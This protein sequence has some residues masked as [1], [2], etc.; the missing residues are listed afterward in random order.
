MLDFDAWL[1]ENKEE[2]LKA[3]QDYIKDVDAEEGWILDY[4]YDEGD[5][6]LDVYTEYLS[7]LSE[8]G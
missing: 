4:D 3:Y 6:Y 5:Y 7:E 1:E 8:G 2:L